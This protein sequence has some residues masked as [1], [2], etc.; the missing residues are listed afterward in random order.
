MA[1]HLAIASSLRQFLSFNPDIS[2]S[3][4]LRAVAGWAVAGITAAVR[5]TPRLEACLDISGTGAVFSLSGV[6]PPSTAK[7]RGAKPTRDLAANVSPL[8]VV[9]ELCLINTTD[10]CGRYWTF[11]A[12]IVCSSAQN[13]LKAQIVPIPEY[14]TAEAS[15][16]PTKLCTRAHIPMEI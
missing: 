9:G 15:C 6:F 13:N 3:E 1:L 10:A 14:C 16:R 11:V 4:D 2:C 12:T 8:V 5:Y 7:Q